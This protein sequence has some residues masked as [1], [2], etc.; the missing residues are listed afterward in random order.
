M[1]LQLET[2][3]ENLTKKM[4]VSTIFREMEFS[5]FLLQKKKSHKLNATGFETL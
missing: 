1:W 4:F 5:H 2:E 3:E